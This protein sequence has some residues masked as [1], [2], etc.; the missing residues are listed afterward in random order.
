MVRISAAWKA[1]LPV[2]KLQRTSRLPSCRARNPPPMPHRR[3]A[4]QVQ[5]LVEV[6]SGRWQE[7]KQFE[8]LECEMETG[9]LEVKQRAA[10]SAAA[11]AAAKGEPP[12]HP[13]PP[14][15]E[16]ELVFMGQTCENGKQLRDYGICHDWIKQVGGFVL[17]PRFL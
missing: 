1:I 4:L 9:I 2:R 14:P 11:S 8:L 3:T 10:G 13:G 7:R 12:L 6:R 17:K 15:E 16:Q 5:I